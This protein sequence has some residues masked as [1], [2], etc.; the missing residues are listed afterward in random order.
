MPLP[1]VHSLLHW[2]QECCEPLPGCRQ[3]PAF[4]HP[5]LPLATTTCQ[6]EGGW[7]RG[8]CSSCEIGSWPQ[9]RETLGRGC[10]PHPR[11]FQGPSHSGLARRGAE[12]H[13]QMGRPAEEPANFSETHLGDTHPCSWLLS[14]LHHL[15][16]VPCCPPGKERHEQNN[17][18]HLPNLH[19]ESVASIKCNYLILN[20]EQL[21]LHLFA[22][23]S[24]LSERERESCSMG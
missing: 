12:Q 11:Y 8:G 5:W 4:Q 15:P 17:T 7:R 6:A 20:Q 2:P 10:F 14:A 9:C 3:L 16:E 1:V 19:L 21:L 13:S 24:G 23:P 18:T 22:V